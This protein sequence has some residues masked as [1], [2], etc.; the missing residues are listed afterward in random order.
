MWAG[1]F[2][3]G[4]MERRHESEYVRPMRVLI[5]EDEPSVADLLERALK[6]ATWASDVVRTGAAAIEAMSVVDYDLAV[7]D[8]GLPDM[9]GF[10]VCR[11]WRRQ[12]GKTPVLILTARQDLRDRVTGLDAGADDYLG[13]PFAVQEL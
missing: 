2:S 13:K 7:L 6:E 8:V 9:S 10:D 11:T 4:G 1:H 3:G 12:G 5:V